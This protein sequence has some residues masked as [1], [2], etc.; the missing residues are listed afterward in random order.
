MKDKHR[1]RFVVRC[2]WVNMFTRRWTTAL[3]WEE[4][5]RLGQRLESHSPKL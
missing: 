4:K 2:L 1:K 5:F 3:G